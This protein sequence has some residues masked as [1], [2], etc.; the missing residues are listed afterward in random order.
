MSLKAK[1]AGFGSANMPTMRSTRLDVAVVDPRIC[2]AHSGLS[3]SSSKVADRAQVQEPRNVVVAGHAELARAQDVSRRQ[4]LQPAV[5]PLELLQPAGKLCSVSCAGV[6]NAERVEEVS[7]RDVS[8][9]GPRRAA[10][11]DPVEVLFHHRPVV[12]RG[13]RKHVVVRQE[14]VHAVDGDELLGQ[15]STGTP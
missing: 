7:H 9:H 3:V 10:G 14:R 13:A 6:G 1:P 12:V 4:I 8:D 11:R 15:R 5:G 2:L